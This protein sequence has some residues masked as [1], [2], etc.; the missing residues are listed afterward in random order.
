MK[1]YLWALLVVG[2]CLISCRTLN[3][4]TYISPNKEFVL[5]QWKHGSYKAQLTNVDEADIEIVLTDMAG[6]RKSAGILYSGTS[7]NLKIPAD[8][9]VS[10]VNLGEETAAIRLKLVGDTRL[11]MGYQ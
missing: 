10:F 3:S 1:K 4:T 2:A 5:G 8:K 11:S 6:Q 9:Q 7:Q